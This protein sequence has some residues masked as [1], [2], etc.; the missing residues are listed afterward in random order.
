MKFVLTFYGTR[1]DVE[2]GVA[3]GRELLRRGHDVRMAVPPDLVSFAESAGLAAVAYGPDTQAWLE[4]TR[5]FWKRFFRNVWN[6]Q[7]VKKLLRESREPGIQCWGEMSTTLTSLADGADLLLTGMSY[8]ELATNVA[9][10]CDIPLATLLWFPI[11]VNGHLV[12]IFPA[13]LIRSAMTVHE[14]LVWRGVKKVEGAQRR[15]L[16][17]PKATGPAPRRIAEQGSLEIQAYDEVCFPGLAVEWAKF[18]GQRPFV[19]TLTMEMTTAADAEV[20]SWI[21]AG[22]PPIFFGFG[23]MPVESPADTVAMIAAAC[24]QLGERALVGTGSGWSE[25]SDMPYFEHVKV[26]DTVNFAATFPACRAVVHHGGAGTTAAGLRAGVPTL[27]LWMLDVQVIWGAAVKRLKVG[28]ARRFSTTT[29]K[30]LVSDLRKILAPQYV[31]RA[32]EIATRMTEPA[33]SVAA[34]ADLVEDFARFKRVG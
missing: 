26:V 19:G 2:P 10:Y 21:A 9:E 18:D 29:E 3:V 6:I 15:E 17:L 34:A 7:E 20:A 31:D 12:P 28:T 27:I 30:S 33:K 14:W 1:G 25:F 5:D 32:R 4:V 16:G 23:S 13:P 11:R 8:Q 22:T 24:T